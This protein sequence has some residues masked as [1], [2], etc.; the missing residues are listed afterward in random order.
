[1]TL[2]AYSAVHREVET[3]ALVA[4]RIVNPDIPRD[5]FIATASQSAS[6]LQRE[7][8]SML[9]AVARENK[10]ILRWDFSI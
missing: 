10:D 9:K 5:I 8:I 2:L 6:F 3:G 1:M 4:R 7:A